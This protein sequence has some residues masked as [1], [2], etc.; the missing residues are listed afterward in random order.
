[1]MFNP[2]DDERLVELGILD[3]STGLQYTSPRERYV[4]IMPWREFRL[5]SLALLVYVVFYKGR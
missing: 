3:P 5:H 2:Y 4:S 1:M